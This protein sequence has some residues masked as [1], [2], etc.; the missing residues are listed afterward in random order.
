VG[1]SGFNWRNKMNSQAIWRAVLGLLLL[2]CAGCSA[3]VRPT[4]AESEFLSGEPK[5]LGGVVLVSSEGFRGYTSKQTDVMDMKSWSLE[6]GPA[7]ADVKTTMPLNPI[8]RP[9]KWRG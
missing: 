2:A 9:S 6:L 5:V 8:P 1:I 3:T 7:A 4:V